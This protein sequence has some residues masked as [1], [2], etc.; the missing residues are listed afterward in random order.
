MKKLTLLLLF[1]GMGTFLMAQSDEMKPKK[2]ENSSWHQMV[3]VKFKAGKVGEARKLI[4]KY[5]TAGETA[6]TPAPQTFWFV[7]GPY[8]MLLIWDFENG[9]SD[10]EWQWDANGIKWWKAFIEQEGSEEAAQKIQEEYN[11]LVAGSKSEI[12]RKD[13]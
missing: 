3:C 2:Y 1:I 5:V 13:N 12:V 6:G 11:A 8:D 10:L 7:T 9:P 4:E